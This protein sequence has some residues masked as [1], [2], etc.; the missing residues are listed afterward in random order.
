MVFP[1]AVARLMAHSL[2]FP[3]TG[4]PAFTPAVKN[5]KLLELINIVVTLP[6]DVPACAVQASSA[7]T[8]AAVMREI[9]FIL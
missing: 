8:E 3:H 9:Y 5:K 1:C 2:L 4:D 7:R 6:E